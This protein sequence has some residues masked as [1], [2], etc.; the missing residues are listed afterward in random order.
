MAPSKRLSS[1]KGWCMRPDL[2]KQVLN[3]LDDDGLSFTFNHSDESCGIIKDY[4]THIMGAFVCEHSACSSKGWGSKKIAIYIRLYANQRYNAQVY[5]Q[6]C[7][8]CNHLGKLVPDADC[9]ADR[10]AYRLKKWSGIAAERPF[11]QRKNGE[12]HETLFCEGCKNGHCS[13]GSRMAP[14]DWDDDDFYGQMAG[15]RLDD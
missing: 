10:V 13:E 14:A 7:K 3:L 12:P 15:L 8:Q 11:Y 5:R 6:R 9:Y 2:H 4:D 1:G